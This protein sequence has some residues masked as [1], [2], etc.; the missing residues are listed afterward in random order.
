MYHW[1]IILNQSFQKILNIYF[2]QDSWPTFTFALLYWVLQWNKS[3]CWSQNW[4]I[5]F[6]ATFSNVSTTLKSADEEDV[7]KLKGKGKKAAKPSLAS[8][9]YEEKVVMYLFLFS[10][11]IRHSNRAFTLCTHACR[12]GNCVFNQIWL[13]QPQQFSVLKKLKI[14]LEKSLNLFW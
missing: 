12:M 13:S 9:D 3:D 5:L 8:P 1:T 11:N 4:F 6:Y 7:A 2:P 14:V 10:S